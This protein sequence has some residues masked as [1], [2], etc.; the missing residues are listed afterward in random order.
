M[1]VALASFLF[2]PEIGGG[3]AAVARFLADSLCQRGLQVVV[4]TTYPGQTVT[5]EHNDG[6]SLYRVP[7]WNLY[8]VGN[9]DEQPSWKRVLW[10]LIDIWNPCTFWIIRH[11]LEREWPDI[12]H[13]IKLRGLSPSIWTA[14]RVS[15]IDRVV[16][17]CQ[18]YELMSPEGTLSGRIGT[19]A[20]DGHWLLYP[21]QWIRARLS[22]VVAGATAPSRYTLNTLVKS[23]FFPQALKLVVP[24]PHGFTIRQLDQLREL[25][26]DSSDEKHLRL[27]YLGRLE[28]AK[29]IEVLCKAFEV[30]TRRFPHLHL[31][32]A[33]WGTLEPTLRQRYAKHPQVTLHGPVFG[34][35]KARLLAASDVLVV[36]SIWPE[37]F[38]IVIT[39]AYAYGKPV[40]ATRSGGIPELV[41]EGETGF[42]VPPRN[43]EALVDALSHVAENPETVHRMAPACFEVAQ[44]Y[45]LEHVTEEY[46]SV[47]RAVMKS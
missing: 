3:A 1:K 19:W 43:L 35:N 17:T 24:N 6:I 28:K 25:S 9:K 37:V 34:E 40:I 33:G 18:D 38:G 31:D 29:G 42:L 16:Q 10:Q 44:Q 21:Y 30:C 20:H 47:Y 4:I 23:G 22:H 2:K 5:V 14:A 39:E 41:K 8:W 7:P 27:L 45:T 11:V 32:I 36:P 26:K 13:V 12:I 46:L 15:G